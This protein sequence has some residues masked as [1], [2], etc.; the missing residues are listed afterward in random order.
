[1]LKQHKREI[2]SLLASTPRPK[3]EKARIR[4]EAVI[5]DDFT[6]EAYE[7]LQLSCE[8]LV[9]R[10][11]FIGSSKRCP[12]DMVGCISTLIWASDRVDV[13]ELIQIRK[14]FKYKYGS[15]FIKAAEDNEGDVVNDRVSA[16]LSVIPPSGAVV[17]SY[18]LKIA[19]E[20][21]I[22]W[23]PSQE[24][25]GEML[26]IGGSVAVPSGYSV[27]VA[28]AAGR[29]PERI[30]ATDLSENSDHRGGDDGDG[31]DDGDNG[32]EVYLPSPPKRN[33]AP[34]V[35]MH[36]EEAEIYYPGTA[37][38]DHLMIPKAPTNN[39]NDAKSATTLYDIT[40][41]VDIGTNTPGI[42]VATASYVDV[43]VDVN[44]K[45]DNDNKKEDEISVPAEVTSVMSLPTSAEKRKMNA[46]PSAPPPLQAVGEEQEVVIPPAPSFVPSFHGEE[47]KQFDDDDDDDGDDDGSKF[48]CNASVDTYDRLTA[49]FAS[50]T[51]DN[52]SVSQAETSTKT[53]DGK[54]SCNTGTDNFDDLV[55]RFAALKK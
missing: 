4:A 50:M 39:I 17:R 21:D 49:R 42:P 35:A 6:V 52:A 31:N 2:A 37:D 23:E 22:N 29:R 44:E 36:V 53:E 34:P 15:R 43:D 33:P 19:E 16:R 18:L 5:R 13:P 20:F 1:M 48:S 10:V 3:E 55:A 26:N 28:E 12:A 30:A 27:P 54:H 9:E 14:Q 45:D 32:V 11:K 41:T 8:L 7:I 47:K 24:L 38:H 40:A 25:Q 51:N 46:A